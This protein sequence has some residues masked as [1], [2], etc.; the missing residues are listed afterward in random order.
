MNFIDLF[1]GIGGFHI[2]LTNLNYNCVFACDIDK[3]CR[4]TYEKNFK[5]KV[6]D[7]ITKVNVKDIPSFDILC[8]GFPC[9]PF[10]KAGYQ[11]GF[12]DKRGNLF[13]YIC[14]II[15][16]HKPK[17]LILENVKNLATHDD[18]NTWLTIKENLDFLNYYTYDKPVILNTL[19]FNIPQNRERV[20][21]L[22]K[23]KDLGTLP[24]LPNI[25]KSPKK[26]LTNFISSIINLSDD[27]DYTL[28]LN[29]KL[30]NVKNIW[31]AFIQ[32]IKE[33]NISIPKFP[34]WT[35]WFDNEIDENNKKTYIKYKSWIDKNREFYKI[36]Y[37]ILKPW[38]LESR[39][40]ID[41]NGSMRKLEWQAGDLLDDDDFSKILWT[42]RSSGVRVKRP[43]Y[44]P[45]LVAMSHIPIYGPK[46]RKLSA[47]ELLRLQSFPDT[48][49][50]DKK[51][52][53]KQV[54]NAVNVKMI[55]KSARFLIL[56]ESLF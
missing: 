19:H 33:N 55:E 1:S 10:S 9:Q 8:A 52:I 26:Y 36:N 38:L 22:C 24:L 16:Y 14:D 21:I 42:C 4:D 48:F 40:N 18:G 53:L 46:D 41:W 43:D 45:T 12:D 54:G 7:D 11:K 2:A 44:I 30:E 25:P 32:L 3:K 27:N 35:D 31:N 5:L 20:I 50:F 39:N 17:Y 13:F 37:N 23:R 51:Y 47:R 15:Q 56:N 6:H 34:I 49:V 28:K 29:K